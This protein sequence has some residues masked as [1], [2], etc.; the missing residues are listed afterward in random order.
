M[1]KNKGFTLIELLAVIVILAI[2]AVIATPM[3]LK[4]IDTAKEGAND[5][6]VD[7]LVRAAN[8]YYASSLL[9]TDSTY[10]IEFDLS[11]PADVKK[12]GLKGSTPEEGNLRINSDGTT[13]IEVK[14]DGVL[15]SKYAEETKVTKNDKVIGLS[16]VW[17][18]DGNGKITDYKESP[19]TMATYYLEVFY[20]NYALSAVNYAVDPRIDHTQTLYEYIEKLEQEQGFSKKGLLPNYVAE[21]EKLFEVLNTSTTLTEEEALE[22]VVS[23]ASDIPNIME[24]Y[25]LVGTNFD[26][27]DLLLTQAYKNIYN[28]IEATNTYVIPNIVKH[29]D[30][31]SEEITEIGSGTF[32]VQLSSFK[33]G[34]KLIIS[35]GIKKINNLA[36][37]MQ[38]FSEVVLPTTLESIG[39]NAF[40]ANLLTSIK[41]PSRLKSIGSEAFKH[42]MLSG[43]LIIP[44]SVEKIGNRAFTS[45]NYTLDSTEGICQLDMN[46]CNALNGKANN[47]TKVIIKRANGDGLS[48][49]STAFDSLTPVYQP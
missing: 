17:E 14:Y 21:L 20:K 46:Y 30:G 10:P 22:K 25:A 26:A 13:H 41:L 2:I 7:A 47:I 15:Y 9:K 19:L 36:F 1:K 38:G 11:D 18:T 16:S 39:G 45:N 24:I 28:S 8:N 23:I 31:T 27:D 6:S 42:N 32:Y 40:S 4:Y 34:R 48:I 49:D 44:K 33:I 35:N 12:L 37:H 29:E 3:V 43:E 5:S